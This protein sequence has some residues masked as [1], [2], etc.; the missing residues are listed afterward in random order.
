MIMREEE[1]AKVRLL[2]E[3]RGAQI[4]ALCALETQQGERVLR[5]ELSGG[6]G[7]WK[8]ISGGF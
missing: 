6:Y 7:C 3:P 5:E 1:D 4:E 2:F 8:D